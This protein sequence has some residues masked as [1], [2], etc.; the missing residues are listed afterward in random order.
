MSMYLWWSLR[1]L[2]LL[3]CLVKVTIGNSGLCCCV[4]VMSSASELPLCSLLTNESQLDSLC[5]FN[6]VLPW[7][8]LT[9][10]CGLQNDYIATQFSHSKQKDS[11]LV[12]AGDTLGTLCAS[13]HQELCGY[14]DSLPPVDQ[15]HQQGSQVDVADDH[16]HVTPSARRKPS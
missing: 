14:A 5:Y 4:Q 6:P 13:A 8:T 11:I 15:Q 12:S 10:L 2:Y 1:I 9:L 7:Q 3:A 16:L